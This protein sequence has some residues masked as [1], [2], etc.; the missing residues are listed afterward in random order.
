MEKQLIFLLIGADPALN[1]LISNLLK[2]NNHV[3]VINSEYIESAHDSG[4]TPYKDLPVDSTARQTRLRNSIYRFLSTNEA[5]NNRYDIILDIDSINTDLVKQYAK[6]GKDTGH[7]LVSVQADYIKQ[8]DLAKYL[9]FVKSDIF[10]QLSEML[11]RSTSNSRIIFHRDENVRYVDFIAALHEKSTLI[12]VNESNLDTDQEDIFKRLS[13]AY[14]FSHI[15]LT[16]GTVD[17][18]DPKLLINKKEFLLDKRNTKIQSIEAAAAPTNVSPS[19]N[20]LSIKQLF[21][22]LTNELKARWT[23]KNASKNEQNKSDRE[24][25]LQSYREE[26]DKLRKDKNI[27]VEENVPPA[28]NEIV[29]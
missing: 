10:E 27:P 3:K 29:V 25:K 4:M 15:R 2:T 24:Q 7:E 13:S 8:N 26:S 18:T 17:V 16:T 1:G 6:I 9:F 23:K 5:Q 21:T 19:K 14:G 12:L 22:D 28:S 20:N 11:N